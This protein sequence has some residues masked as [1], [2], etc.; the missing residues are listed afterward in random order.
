MDKCLITDWLFGFVSCF[1]QEHGDMLYVGHSPASAF[2]VTQLQIGS[3][4][5]AN[6]YVS[7]ICILRHYPVA[8]F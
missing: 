2:L 7:C 3:L 8:H 4:F 5:A 1:R 6:V